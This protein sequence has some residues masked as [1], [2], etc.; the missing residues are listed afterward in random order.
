MK[1][2]GDRRIIHLWPDLERSL[3]YSQAAV[4]GDSVYI[5]GTVAFDDTITYIGAT[6]G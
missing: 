3:G 5:A 2:E 6:L 1:A 4:I